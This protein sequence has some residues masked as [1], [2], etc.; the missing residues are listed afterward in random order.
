MYRAFLMKL[1]GK[2]DEKRFAYALIVAGVA[3]LIAFNS[4]L[5]DVTVWYLGF[6]VM[7]PVACVPFVLRA[8]AE[9]GNRGEER[10]PVCDDRPVICEPIICEPKL[11]GGAVDTDAEREQRTFRCR[12]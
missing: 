8:D 4:F 3:Y 11:I 1:W 2:V 6:T 5:P 9:A 10:G 12:S 7:V